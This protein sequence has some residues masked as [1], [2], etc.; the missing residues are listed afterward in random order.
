MLL[1]QAS[2]AGQEASTRFGTDGST[3]GE[4]KG[5]RDRGTGSELNALGYTIALL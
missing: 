2:A 3:A 1:E 5:K 4:T